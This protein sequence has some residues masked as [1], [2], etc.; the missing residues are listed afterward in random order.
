MK[1]EREKIMRV[2]RVEATTAT[3]GIPALHTQTSERKLFFIII[4]IKE[5]TAAA[6]AAHTQFMA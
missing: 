4:K 1:S 6:A 3:L 2:S 5:R